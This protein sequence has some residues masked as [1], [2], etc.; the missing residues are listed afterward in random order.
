MGAAI[1]N[2]V[3]KHRRLTQLLVIETMFIFLLQKN[4]HEKRKYWHQPLFASEKL[5]KIRIK[6]LKIRLKTE[7]QIS[8]KHLKLP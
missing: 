7:F 1:A 6:T 8:V 2:V 5:D 3:L 4:R